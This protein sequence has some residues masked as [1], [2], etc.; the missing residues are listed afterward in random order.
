[1][2]VP[3]LVTERLILRAHVASDLEVCAATWADPMVMRHISGTPSTR[4]QAWARL[5]R[6]L[7]HWHAMG[8]GLW[9]AFESG[10]GRYVGDLGIATFERDLDPQAFAALATHEAGWVLA[11]WA[12]GHGFATEGMRAALTW[13]DATFPDVPTGCIIDPENSGSLRVAE[14]LGYREVHRSEYHG[15][16]SVIFHRTERS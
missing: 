7:G 4:E 14:K 3:E 8:F 12:H 2:N 9:A 5:C 1:M 15:K 10:T 11:S 16:P 13:H 6:N